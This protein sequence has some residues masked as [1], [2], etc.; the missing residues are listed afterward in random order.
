MNNEK[1]CLTGIRDVKNLFS[2]MLAL[3]QE[4]LKLAGELSSKPELHEKMA[5]LFHKRKKVMNR[6]DS[7]SA[8]IKRLESAQI[9]PLL[10]GE[11]IKNLQTDVPIMSSDTG[12]EQILDIIYSIEENDRQSR[13]IIDRIFKQV[14]NKL[15]NC[16]I[17][18]KAYNAYNQIDTYSEGWFFDGKK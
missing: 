6:I 18:K 3:S 7:L 13:T 10:D 2:Q 4:Q 17:N 8:K 1:E 14:E 15:A 5:E 9:D 12:K 11:D 16:K